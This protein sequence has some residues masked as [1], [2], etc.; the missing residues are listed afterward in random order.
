MLEGRLTGSG[1]EWVP[2]AVIE[3]LVELGMATHVMI[4]EANGQ[5]D[6]TERGRKALEIYKL[7]QKSGGQNG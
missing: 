1:L 6:V 7:L 5:F 2:I 4:D 3:S